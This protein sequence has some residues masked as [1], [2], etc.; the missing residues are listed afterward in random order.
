MTT[1]D[2]Y[3]PAIVTGLATDGVRRVAWLMRDADA[4]MAAVVAPL[5]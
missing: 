2:D 1:E 3:R 5:A 4:G